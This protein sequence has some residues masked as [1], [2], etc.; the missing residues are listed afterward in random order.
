MDDD[1]YN[2]QRQRTTVMDKDNEMMTMMRLMDGDD[3]D[4]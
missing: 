4:G 3:D 1:D 2:G